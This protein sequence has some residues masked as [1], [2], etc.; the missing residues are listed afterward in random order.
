MAALSH[1]TAIQYNKLPR[2]TNEH[3]TIPKA[4]GTTVTSIHKA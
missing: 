3:N 4:Q 1:P 2:S